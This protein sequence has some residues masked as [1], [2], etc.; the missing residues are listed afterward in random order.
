MRLFI[1]LFTF[2][3]K[4]MLYQVLITCK[5]TWKLVLINKERDLE[6]KECTKESPK[7]TV[8]K[9]KP[10]HM[11]KANCFVLSMK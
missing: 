4:D 10:D 7:Q 2:P 1:L 6:M 5:D 8:R 9:P 11:L 3:P